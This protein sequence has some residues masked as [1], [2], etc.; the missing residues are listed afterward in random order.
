MDHRPTATSPLLYLLRLWVGP[1]HFGHFP[2]FFD[3]AFPSFNPCT[4]K[5]QQKAWLERA[6]AG[7]RS[8]GCALAVAL[9]SSTARRNLRAL[10]RRDARPRWGQCCLISCPCPDAT[11]WAQARGRPC[12]SSPYPFPSL[13]HQPTRTHR[14]CLKA[15]AFVSISFSLLALAFAALLALSALAALSFA[16]AVT[17]LELLGLQMRQVA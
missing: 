2:G 11:A 13:Q 8:S 5:C 14:F 15:P 9:Q 17:L 16:L 3:A 12:P 1:T 10:S 4:R 7:N 6:A